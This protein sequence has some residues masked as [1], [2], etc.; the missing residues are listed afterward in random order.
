MFTYLRYENM[1]R[2]D[3]KWV[4]GKLII[5]KIGKYDTLGEK[6]QKRCFTFFSNLH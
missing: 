5:P 4:K 3:K 2:I 6:C 1:N